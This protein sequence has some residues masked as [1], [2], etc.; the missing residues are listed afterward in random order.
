MEKYSPRSSFPQIPSGAACAISHQ[1]QDDGQDLAV[2]VFLFVGWVA[3]VALLFEGTFRPQLQIWLLATHV[4]INTN[5]SFRPV[6]D[7]SHYSSANGRPRE[8]VV[9]FV[10]PE[11]VQERGCLFCHLPIGVQRL[12][13]YGTSEEMLTKRNMGVCEKNLTTIKHCQPVSLTGV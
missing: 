13:H 4:R 8:V 11:T 7:S 2:T 10:E 1:R 6:L 3:M 5:H 12:R 9:A